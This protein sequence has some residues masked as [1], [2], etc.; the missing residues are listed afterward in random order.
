MR[1]CGTTIFAIDQGGPMASLR[2][3]AVHAGMLAV[4]A[5][6]LYFSGARTAVAPQ[7]E[8]GACVPGHEQPRAASAD[9][10]QKALVGHLSRRYMIAAE[11]TERLV[12]AADRAARQVGLDPLL[13]LAVIAIESRFNPFAE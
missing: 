9:A 4:L 3:Q 2:K 13:V 6:A 7:R 10:A 12:G 11:A 8:M 5:A 1:R